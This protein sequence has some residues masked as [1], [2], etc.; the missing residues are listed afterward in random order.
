MGGDTGE[1]FQ[2]AAEISK[3]TADS[4]G[5]KYFIN[6]VKN[7]VVTVVAATAVIQGHMTLG[8]MLAVQY[9]I[10]Q[11]NSPVEQLMNF[12]YSVQDVKSVWNESMR[13]IRWMMRTVRRAC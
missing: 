11:L 13:F 1:S 2:G 10:G 9:I 6:E 12:F 8:M 3:T 4:G 7:I 5:R